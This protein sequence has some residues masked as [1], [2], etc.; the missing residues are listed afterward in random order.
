MYIKT[1]DIIGY[2]NPLFLYESFADVIA[3][4]IIISV[5]KSNNYFKEGTQGSTF[6]IFYGI[7]RAIMEITRDSAYQM[8]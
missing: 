2:R 1:G 3:F 6:L 8:K 5:I 7:I 4:V